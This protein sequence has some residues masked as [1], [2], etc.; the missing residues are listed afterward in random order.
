MSTKQIADPRA[1]PEFRGDMEQ[2]TREVSQYLEQH[3]REVH[4]ELDNLHAA[5]ADVTP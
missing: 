3:L 1:F 2:W 4:E 5:K